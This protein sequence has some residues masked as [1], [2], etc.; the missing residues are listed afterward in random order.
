VLLGWFGV[1]KIKR[2]RTNEDTEQQDEEEETADEQPEREPSVQRQKDHQPDA[3]PTGYDP[4]AETRVGSGTESGKIK[5]LL[6]HNEGRHH[7]DGDHSKREAARDKKRVT[8]S[9]CSALGV[10][11]YQ[12]QQATSAMGQM[13]LDRFGQQKRIEKVALC[14][15]KIVVNHDREQYFLN[16]NDPADLDLSAIDSDQFPT[17]FGQGS[18]FS[19]LCG[20]HDLSE[21]DKNTITKIVKRELKQL[22]YFERSN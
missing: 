22:G 17:K 20:Q 21:S 2:I 1:G 11:P 13:N 19:S 15:I 16:G 6:R 18:Q 9:L 10:T 3:Y 8:Q 7:S 5:R 14:T 12:Q 4:S